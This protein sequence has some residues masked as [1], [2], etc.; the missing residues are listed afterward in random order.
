MATLT[1]TIR[2]H[3]IKSGVSVRKIHLGTGLPRPTIANFRDGKPVHS[4][5]LDKLA[6]FLGASVSFP[7]ADKPAKKSKPGK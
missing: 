1:E 6:E 7:T 3:F 5:T 2:N 4:D